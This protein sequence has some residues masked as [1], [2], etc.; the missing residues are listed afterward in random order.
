MG[1]VWVHVLHRRT[2]KVILMSNMRKKGT[3]NNKETDKKQSSMNAPRAWRVCSK[4]QLSSVYYHSFQISLN[5]LIGNIF[6]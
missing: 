3:R 5:T 2:Y 6:S 4:L 1:L